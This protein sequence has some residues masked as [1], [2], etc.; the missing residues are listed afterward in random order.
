MVS[1]LVS[2]SFNAFRQKKIQLPI[3]NGINLFLLAVI[4][5]MI[6]YVMNSNTKIIE[7]NTL[8][9]TGKDTDGA[10]SQAEAP[11]AITDAAMPA[12]DHV[13]ER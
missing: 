4:V 1:S 3:L 12:A 2:K 13:T 9:E 8:K 11:Y 7:A 6:L 5:C 10:K